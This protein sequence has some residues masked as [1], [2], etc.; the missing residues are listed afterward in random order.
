MSGYY[1]DNLT[2]TKIKPLYEKGDQLDPSIY[3]PMAL[4]PVV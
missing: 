3:R 1:P 4:L 2:I